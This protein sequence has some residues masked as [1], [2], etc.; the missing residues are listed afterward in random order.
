MNTFTRFVATATLIIGVVP[1]SASALTLSADGQAQLA[2]IQSSLMNILSQ[3]QSSQIQ[4]TTTGVGNGPMIPAGQP[5]PWTGEL[6]QL[7]AQ[8]S[9]LIT[10]QQHSDTNSGGSG[11]PTI[12]TSLGLGSTGDQVSQLQTFL[13]A[14]SSAH[15][16]A[17]SR[18]P[19]MPP[20][21]PRSSASRLRITSSLRVPRARPD[22]AAEEL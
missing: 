21:R 6:S 10:A 1:L 18:E 13:K 9:A 3:I 4:G 19:L 8:I 14:D 7:Q 16:S 11:C 12:T 17:I 15:T 22:M 5:Q 2:Q 20:H